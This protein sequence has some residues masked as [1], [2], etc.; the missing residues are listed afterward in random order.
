[1]RFG[2]KHPEGDRDWN[3]LT[4]DTVSQKAAKYFHLTEEEIFE[5]IQDNRFWAWRWLFEAMITLFR[6][7]GRERKNLVKYYFAVRPDQRRRGQPV[8]DEDDLTPLYE[9]S[10]D[11]GNQRQG[12]NPATEEGVASADIQ[13]FDPRINPVPDPMQ[14]ADELKFDTNPE[15]EYG[16][17]APNDS[18][19]DENILRPQHPSRDQKRAILSQVDPDL[20]VFVDKLALDEDFSKPLLGKGLAEFDQRKLHKLSNL[21]LRGYAQSC[22][23]SQRT[24]ERRVEKI[25]R[26]ATKY[27]NFLS[28]FGVSRR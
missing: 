2:W 26:L 7:L 19:L 18:L 22:G 8:Q 6:K 12:V 4:W 24:G 23:L 11:I 5:H 28:R 10:E 14:T 27:K 3:T 16:S 1:S 13:G 17:E 15:G 21:V 25:R 9:R 20:L